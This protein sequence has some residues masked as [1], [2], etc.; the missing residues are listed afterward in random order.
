MKSGEWIVWRH[1]LANDTLHLRYAHALRT[2]SR[3]PL[4][5][6]RTRLMTVMMG[7]H[8]VTHRSNM[9]GARSGIKQT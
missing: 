6:T 4:A 1:H 8:A 7:M 9:R 5:C 2:S 3:L